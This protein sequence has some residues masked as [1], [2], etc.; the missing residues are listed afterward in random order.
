MS[1]R[2]NP[3]SE[4]PRNLV[5]DAIWAGVRAV[6][7][8][9]QAADARLVNVFVL[10]RADGVPSGEPDTGTGGDGFED[11]K[12][13]VSHLAVHFIAAAESVGLQ[14]QLIPMKQVGEG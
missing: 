4:E 6:E 1:R 13:L 12:D 2:T 3:P 8:Q 7:A 10:V 9:L 14:V 5:E 11:A